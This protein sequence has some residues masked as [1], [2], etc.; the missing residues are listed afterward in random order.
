MTTYRGCARHRQPSCRAFP[1]SRWARPALIVSSAS[2]TLALLSAPVAA[3]AR[4]AAT[5]PE[6]SAVASSASHWGSFFGNGTADNDRLLSPTP[7]S[8]PAAVTEVASS[9]STQYA[10]LANGA[11]YAWGLGGDGQL[12]DGGTADSFTTPVEVDFPTGVKIA[13]LP[14]DAMPFNTG[15]AVDESG[16]VWG[17]GDD[18]SGQLCLGTHQQYLKPVELPLAHVTAL[19]GA[20]DHALYFADGTLEACGG[21]GDGDLG[22]GSLAPSMTPVPVSGF[23]GRHVRVLVASY[24]DSGALLAD[25]QYFDWGYDGQGQ[26]GNGTTGTDS[27]LPVSVHIPLSVSQVVEGGSFTGNGQTLVLLSGG[28]IDA[29]GANQS[30][31]LG[32]GA[33]VGEPS[34]VVVTPPPGVTYELLASGATTSYGLT[35]TGDL[36]SWGGSTDGQVGNGGTRTEL[37]PVMVES[38]VSTLSSTALDV[39]TGPAST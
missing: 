19:A 5:S 32:N 4:P 30:G 15:L 37:S 21:N 17:W 25:G 14:T 36:Y 23:T 20:G 34:P 8:L 35:T 11:V 6:R 29:W 16:H 39:V 38:G 28:T 10:L 3:G 18:S 2:L 13:S 12:G 26:L 7:I 24:H 1:A 33:T 31:Q 27:D 9:N 22:D